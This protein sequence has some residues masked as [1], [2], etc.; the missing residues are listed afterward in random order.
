M[1]AVQFR[2]SGA[3]QQDTDG[4]HAAVAFQFLTI[5]DTHEPD[6]GT[7]KIQMRYELIERLVPGVVP[8]ALRC[9]DFDVRCAL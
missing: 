1:I 3:E 9:H 8:V 2:A 7:M 5:L 6:V 4:K